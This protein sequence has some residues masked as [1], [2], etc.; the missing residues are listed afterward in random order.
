[1]L[2]I[3]KK[4]LQ[5]EL[6]DFFL[7]MSINIDVTKST[8][9]QSRLKLK[10]TAFIE[11]N[12]V[13]LKEFYKDRRLKLWKGFRLLAVDGSTLQLPFSKDIMKVYGS[14]KTSM[15]PLAQISS[16]FD[17]LNGIIIDAQ[18]QPYN[19]SEYTL[20]MKHLNKTKKRDLLIYDR[21]YVAVWFMFL[22]IIKNRNFVIRM[23]EKSIKEVKCFL[24]SQEDSKIIIITKP[25]W[26]SKNR[27]KALKLPFKKF[28]IR[29]IKIVLYNGKIEVLAT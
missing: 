11:L 6:T 23:H 2:N 4:T 18:I 22:H 17:V 26:K 19:K 10:Y 25:P 24:E 3:L 13:F 27:F 12:K 7:A 16:C 28:K 9:C 20:A 29:L 14:L 1:M 15:M 8:F 21:G 5:K